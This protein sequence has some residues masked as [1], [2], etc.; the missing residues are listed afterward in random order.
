MLLNE[1]LKEHR[2]VQEMKSTLAKQ[3]ASITE[4]RRDFE[5]TIANLQKQVEALTA[6]LKE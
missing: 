1:F 3:E 2:T 5:V 4:Q 6:G